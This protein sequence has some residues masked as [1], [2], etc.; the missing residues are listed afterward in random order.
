MTGEA[1]PVRVGITAHAGPCPHEVTQPRAVWPRWRLAMLVVALGALAAAPTRAFAQAADAEADRIPGLPEP[2]IGTSLPRDL[3]D[4]GGVRSAFAKRGVIF[5]VN[6]IGEVLA[7]PTG[8][9]RQ[10]AFYD[11]RLELAVQADLEKGIGWPGLS[12]FANGYQIHGRSISAEDLGVLMPVSFIEANPSTRL[13]E[14][15]L[16]QKLWDDRLSIRFGQIAADSE[17]LLSKGGEAFLNSTWGWPSITDVN[18]PQ[19]GPAY[20]LATP[21]VRVA[22][23]PNDVV[24]GMLGVFNGDPAGNDCS[25]E[26]DPQECNPDGLLFPI[27]AP[28]LLIAE[29]A[30]KYNQAPGALAGTIKL[31][32]YY[33]FGEFEF[34]RIVSGGVRLAFARSLLSVDGDHGLYG[35]I[36]QMIYRLPGDGDP[37]GISLFGRVVGAPEHNP[38]N[39][40]WE[41]GMTFAGLAAARPNDV[42]GIGFAHTGISPEVSE[43]ERRL[44]R[45]I[46]AS[47]EAVV[48]ASYIAEIVPG[49]IIQ[50]DVQYFW[51][52]GGHVR[53]PNDPSKAVPD[54]AVLG[55]R[56]TINY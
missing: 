56:T 9:Y 23:T 7:N 11:G 31:G 34:Q 37:R 19:N 55:L 6:Y 41:A 44:G 13:F 24:S 27:D 17:F 8:G 3:A 46:V 20:P 28:P 35:I 45:P 43:L 50:P 21:G 52:P 29:G 26:A 22:F 25:P 47:Y 1:Q 32:G 36:D 42:L 51:N 5:A 14:I 16:E 4:P 12:F 39:L 54:A 33:N 10:G 49:F 18:M 30:Y 2:S 48:E 15:W 53:D 40:Y 38:I